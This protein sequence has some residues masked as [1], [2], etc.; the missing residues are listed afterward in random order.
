[1][2]IEFLSNQRHKMFLMNIFLTGGDPNECVAP[3]AGAFEVACEKLPPKTDAA[4]VAFDVGAPKPPALPP[5]KVF[6]PKTEPLDG[7]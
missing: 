2:N 6:V 3:K 1:M 4:V 5:L 7:C